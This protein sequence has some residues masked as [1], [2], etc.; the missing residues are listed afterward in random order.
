MLAAAHYTAA[1][2]CSDLE[3]AKSFYADKL[4][5]TRPTSNS[6]G[7]PTK[8]AAVQSSCF[9]QLWAGIRSYT[10]IGLSVA[11]INAEVRDPEAAGS[12]VRRVR[13]SRHRPGQ[14]P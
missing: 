5:L 9:C 1:L 6:D 2:P 7:C 4:G 11:D 8:G 12:A 14:R 10:Q 13:F 3:R